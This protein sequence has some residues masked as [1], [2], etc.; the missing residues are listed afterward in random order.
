MDIATPEGL[1]AEAE[2]LWPRWVAHLAALAAGAQP[3]DDAGSGAG[4]RLAQVLEALWLDR[5]EAAGVAADG[6][7]EH[8]LCR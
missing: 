6:L 8:V 4:A 7:W 5:G 3:A 2:A 1:A